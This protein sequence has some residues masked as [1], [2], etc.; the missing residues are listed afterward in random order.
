M[1]FAEIAELGVEPVPKW[2]S[3][4]CLIS[5][6]GNILYFACTIIYEDYNKGLLYISATFFISLAA[7]LKI[8]SVVLKDGR[9]FDSIMNQ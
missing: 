6:I 5:I 9:N 7:E 2:S 1:I 3:F 4:L 8:L